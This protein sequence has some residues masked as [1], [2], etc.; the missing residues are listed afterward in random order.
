MKS[1]VSR[2][3]ALMFALP[4]IVCLAIYWK[5]PFMWFRI[6]DFAWLSLPL[7]LH[8]MRDFWLALFEPRAQGTVRTLSER[9]YFLIPASIF[10]LSAVP[11]RVMSLGTWFIDLMLIQAIGARLWNSRAAGFW[12]ALFWAVT[13]V[14]I[15]PLAWSSAYNEL[16]CA[17]CVLTALYARL[18]SLE[19]PQPKWRWI[20]TAA[21]LAGFGALEVIVAYPAIV[22]LHAL[23]FPDARQRWRS[24]LWMFA[25]AILFAAAHIF[26]IPRSPDPTYQM[27]LDM[28]LPGNLLQYAAW[29]V[30]PSELA[31]ITDSLSRQRWE[32]FSI[33]ITWACG[34]AL[35]AFTVLRVTRGDRRVLFCLAWFLCF[36]GPVALLPN[37]VSDYYVTIP[38]IGFAWLAG[39]AMTA[40]LESG[41]FATARRALAM[42]LAAGYLIASTIDVQTATT[43]HLRVTSRMRIL[44]R[45]VQ[46]LAASHPGTVLVLQ[47]VD[48]E[49][50]RAG[51]HDDP[52]RLV[53]FTRV[54]LAPGNAD[55]LL[56]N[57]DVGDV[58]R[59]RTTPNVLM[60]LLDSNEARVLN[61]EENVVRDVTLPYREVLRAQ[62]GAARANRVNLGDGAFAS[63]LGEGWYQ[64]ENGGRWMAKKAAVTL[65]PLPGSSRLYVAGYAPAAAVSAGPLT[66]R[67]TAEGK[68]VGAATVR[69]ADKVFQADFAVPADLVEKR[70]ITIEV[71]C[72]RTFRP[73]GDARDLGIVFESFE[74]R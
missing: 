7:E 19:A 67:F 47:G 27:H 4:P 26:L 30:G 6:D 2:I 73:P 58:G 44:M 51:F 52:F 20:E 72:S 42:T 33:A 16:L 60:P 34:L 65:D 11:F 41:S 23:F 56:S 55:Q 13:P 31:G 29:A 9:L 62:Y 64:I 37:H 45:G 1:T 61:V 8:T 53:G 14:L 40:A 5:A 68:Q 28:R 35:L 63:R 50:F 12:A 39:L 57:P 43:W 69:E 48:E 46:R 74:V 10:G 36:L 71:E 32:P 59:F 38:G 24:S 17:L 54:Y 66:L 21:Y 25:P 15:I 18:R 3:G 70:S 49:L 22:L